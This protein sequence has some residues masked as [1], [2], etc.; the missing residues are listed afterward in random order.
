MSN[1]TARVRF[2]DLTVTTDNDHDLRIS[3]EMDIDIELCDNN[4]SFWLVENVSNVSI[5]AARIAGFN[6]LKM[7]VDNSKGQPTKLVA[8]LLNSVAVRDR[9]MDE[10]QQ[11]GW[12]WSE[13]LTSDIQ[14]GEVM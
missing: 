13:K 14:N 11:L 3:G 4:R 8:K 9:L 5:D 6:F 1:T 2:T 10:A 12:E 7:P